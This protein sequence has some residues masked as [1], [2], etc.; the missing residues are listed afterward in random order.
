MKVRTAYEKGDRVRFLS[1]LDVARVIQITVN[2]AGWPVE[3]SQGFSPRPRLSFYA[4]LPAGTAGMEEYF[5]AVLGSPRGLSGLAKGLSESLP[6]GFRVREIRGIADQEGSLEGK[7][8]ASV[9]SVDLMGVEGRELSEALR[10]FLAEEKVPFDVIRPNETKTVD[11]RHFLL[12]VGEVQ[13]MGFGRVVVDMLVKHEEGRTARPQWILSSLRSFGL[14]V[15][16]REAIIDRRKIIF[17][18]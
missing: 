12:Q 11:L 10:R 6:Q 15:D 8:A 5:D 3:M 13:D 1:H 18:K 16:P 7:I 17:G 4:P 9:Y 14:E 2:R